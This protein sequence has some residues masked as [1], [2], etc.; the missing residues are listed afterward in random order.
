VLRVRRDLTSVNAGRQV[1]RD[2][3]A[4]VDGLRAVGWHLGVPGSF[5]RFH[6]LLA[7]VSFHIAHGK[8]LDGISGE[9]GKTNVETY[10]RAKTQGV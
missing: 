3:K 6:P 1:G 9:I 7:V 4:D 8:G 5:E 2:T 10:A